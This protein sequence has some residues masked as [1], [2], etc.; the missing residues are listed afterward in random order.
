MIFSSR[1]P[2][3]NT[4]NFFLSSDITLLCRFSN[5]KLA[6]QSKVGLERLAQLGYSN[7]HWLGVIYQ[8]RIYNFNFTE[9]IVFPCTQIRLTN[10]SNKNINVFFFLNKIISYN[11]N[12]F[13]DIKFKH[14]NKICENKKLS[15]CQKLWF[16]NL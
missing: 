15:F 5:C 8:L 6:V 3:H 9:N 4:S 14:K 2:L 11:L 1:Y 7:V 12:L 13:L 16:S 10:R